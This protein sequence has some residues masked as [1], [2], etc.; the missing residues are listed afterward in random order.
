MGVAGHP[1]FCA[2]VAHRRLGVDI[3]GEPAPECLRVPPG[4]MVILV[5]A[6]RV[7]DRFSISVF[8]QIMP[9]NVIA[10]AALIWLQ[11][12]TASLPVEHDSD[13]WLITVRNVNDNRR[14]RS[15]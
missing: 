15:R 14:W 12:A 13:C 3:S 5:V 10:G 11:A 1:E 8:P 9:A 4:G 6:G 7:D 2:R